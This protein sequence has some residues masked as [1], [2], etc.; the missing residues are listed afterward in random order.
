MANAFLSLS[1]QALCPVPTKWLSAWPEECFANRASGLTNQY[2]AFWPVTDTS[3][4]SFVTG[5]DMKKI[6]F[7]LVL[8]ALMAAPVICRAQ[9]PIQV[10][11]FVLG[12]DIHAFEQVVRM[13]SALPVRHARYISEVETGELKGFKS[14]I[15]G[16]GTCA[17]P[18]KIVRIKLKYA[19]SS[20]KFY[21][22]LLKRFKKQFG[23][24]DEWRG[25]PF[26]IVLAWKW[27]FT[28]NDGSTISLILQHNTRDSESKI[29]N[30]VKLTRTSQ[31]EKEQAC[32]EDKQ[33]ATKRIASEKS[34]IK[35]MGPEEWKQFVPR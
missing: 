30:A 26:H 21:D 9:A 34:D 23:E 16:Y 24:P 25:D 2:A 5:G 31:I 3:N 11:G 14:G 6:L 17:A 22:S 12:A 33:P 32:Y 28:D 35:R 15:I 18:G 1:G 29:G 20:K 19:E 8:T 13:E 7:L 4:T 27:S 10:A